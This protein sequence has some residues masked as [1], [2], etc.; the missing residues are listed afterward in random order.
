MDI[1]CDSCLYEDR[2]YRDAPCID[3]D[4]LSAYEPKC[5]S[6]TN[7]LTLHTELCSKAKA[8]MTKKNQDYTGG[9]GPF[10]N[11]QACSVIGVDPIQGTIIRMLDKLQRINSYVVNGELAVKDEGLEDTLVDLINYSVLVWGMSRED[12]VQEIASRS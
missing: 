11:L 8:L 7:L 3:C 6:K 9:G 2:S 5:V 4:D 10:A 1:D 12:K